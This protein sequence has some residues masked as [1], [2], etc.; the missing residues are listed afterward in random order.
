MTIGVTGTAP[1]ARLEQI[2]ESIHL[3]LGEPVSEA[4]IA[5]S[6]GT[7]GTIDHD[8]AVLSESQN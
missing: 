2:A 5:E 7:T 8:L 4:L 1:A 3:Q 6:P